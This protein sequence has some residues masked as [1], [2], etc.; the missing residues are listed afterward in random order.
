MKSILERFPAVKM[1]VRT[2]KE[3]TTAYENDFFTNGYVYGKREGA[4][5]LINMLQSAI[6]DNGG[7]TADA[8]GIKM[9]IYNTWKE[10][11]LDGTNFSVAMP[12]K[13]GE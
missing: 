12:I 8:E 3:V 11:C 4:K 2:N 7:F 5:T 13:L 10:I 1:Q 9:L 6:N